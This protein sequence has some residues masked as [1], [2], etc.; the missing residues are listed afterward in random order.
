MTDKPLF[1][2]YCAKDFLTGTTNL[3]IWEEVAY[4]RVIDMIYETN[5]RLADDDKKL[6]WSTKTGSRWPKIKSTLIDLGKIEI[7]DGRISNARCRKELEKVERKIHQK[8]VAGKAS[9]E[10]RKSLK[11]NETGSTGV[12]VPVATEDQR[13]NELSE[14]YKLP[15]KTNT[16]ASSTATLPTVVGC[17]DA[18]VQ[19]KVVSKTTDLFGNTITAEPSDSSDESDGEGR[20]TTLDMVQERGYKAKAVWLAKHFDLFWA[21]FPKRVGS[22]SKDKAVGAFIKAVKASINP[23]R[24]IYGA[25]CFRKNC[26][27][28]GIAVEDGKRISRTVPMASSWL[29][30]EDRNWEAAIEDYEDR[31]KNPVPVKQNNVTHVSF[32]NRPAHQQRQRLAGVAE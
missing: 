1:V 30:L 27:A 14:L 7:I 21:E 11:N 6:G 4:R 25:T 24:I 10:S 20:R 23:E 28:D 8:V 12:E 29:K 18:S 2:Q 17:A 3:S 22:S 26:I 5:D 31:L 16:L 9:A 32:N 13:T 15:S 19:D